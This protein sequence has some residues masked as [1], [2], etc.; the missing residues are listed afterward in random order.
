M[1]ELRKLRQSAAKDMK[2]QRREEKLDAKKRAKEEKK[3]AKLAKKRKGAPQADPVQDA[4]PKTS[5]RK[6]DPPRKRIKIA[7]SNWP[8]GMAPGGPRV[9]DHLTTRTA[10]VLGARAFR[11]A[12]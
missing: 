12:P 2:R 5:G 11:R 7:G 8:P 1:K 10:M 9:P 4:P 6:E 3:A